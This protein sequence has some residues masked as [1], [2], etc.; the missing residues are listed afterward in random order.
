MGWNFLQNQWWILGIKTLCLFPPLCVINKLIDE[1]DILR[2]VYGG[3][4]QH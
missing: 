4:Q 1:K 3:V 2:E